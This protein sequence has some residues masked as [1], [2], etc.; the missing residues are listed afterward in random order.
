VA[1][2]SRA[3]TSTEA[4]YAQ[5]EKESLALTWACECFSDYLIGKLFHMQ[6][7]H[8]PLVSLLG[9]KQLDT[10][11]IQRFRMRLVRFT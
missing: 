5:I 9:S 1:Y 8:K 2:A 6:T 4:K 7:D 11:R 3:L 10:Q